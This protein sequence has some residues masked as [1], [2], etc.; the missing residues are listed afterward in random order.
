MFEKPRFFEKYSPGTNIHNQWQQNAQKC[1]TQMF[2]VLTVACMLIRSHEERKICAE[3]KIIFWCIT[4]L[5]RFCLGQQN[6]K[7]DKFTIL[8]KFN[9]EIVHFPFV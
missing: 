1:T 6:F 7:G 8:F 9:V 3:M 5:I 4:D 2:T